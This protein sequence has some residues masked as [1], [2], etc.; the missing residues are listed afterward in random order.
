[1]LKAGDPVPN[2]ASVNQDG[3]PVGLD[4]YKGRRF[5]IYFY[6]K[7]STPGCTA[8]ACSINA[9]LA[10]LKTLGYDVLGVSTDSVASHARFISKHGLEFPLIADI[11]KSVTKAFGAWGEK[12]MY[13][14]KYEGVFRSTFVVNEE[15]IITH[16]IDKVNTKKHAAQ[17]INELNKK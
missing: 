15:G 8:E 3:M 16:V 2:F 6:P 10:D 12:T 17:I 14:R 4:D 7:D 5:I 1:M 11:D 13:G 9:G